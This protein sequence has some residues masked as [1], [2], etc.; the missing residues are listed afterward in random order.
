MM[1]RICLT[2]F[3]EHM[4]PHGLFV[5]RALQMILLM[6]AGLC[7]ARLSPFVGGES[8]E[9]SPPTHQQQRTISCPPPTNSSWVTRST[10]CRWS[11]QCSRSRSSKAWWW[12]RGRSWW[13]SISASDDQQHGLLKRAEGA[14]QTGGWAAQLG[15]GWRPSIIHQVS[16]ALQIFFA[17]CL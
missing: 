6:S 16:D 11:R 3:E 8:L 10:R 17:F 5:Y 15:A 4:E 1:A 14:V 2:C 9:G 13:W 12:P 7:R